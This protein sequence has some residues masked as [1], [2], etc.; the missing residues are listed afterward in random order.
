MRELLER[1]Q[2]SVCTSL[3]TL[4]GFR[5]R[6]E[7][8]GAAADGA[9]AHVPGARASA[10]SAT[11]PRRRA[12]RRSTTSASPRT[13]SSSSATRRRPSTAPSAR[14]PT[15][16]CGR[17]P[18]SRRGYPD[19]RSCSRGTTPPKSAPRN[20]R[21]PRRRQLDRLRAGRSRALTGAGQERSHRREFARGLAGAPG[22]EL[23]AVHEIV[24]E[25]AARAGST[26][27]PHAEHGW[28]AAG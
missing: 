13:S 5:E 8:S 15:F 27:A 22:P 12:R 24:R 20:R 21:S 23:G 7:R 28:C 14:A 1:E 6:V 16:R 9:L 17:T 3:E 11:A 2:R 26:P 25:P 10:S 18:S 19:W 4:H